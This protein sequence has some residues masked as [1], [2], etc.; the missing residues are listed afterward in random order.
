VCAPAALLNTASARCNTFTQCVP[1]ARPGQSLRP[2][3]PPTHYLHVSRIFKDQPVPCGTA[4]TRPKPRNH[5]SPTS[6]EARREPGSRIPP[7]FYPLD[8]P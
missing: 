8:V 2:R 6:E 4:V 1:D 3:T 7:L 5:L